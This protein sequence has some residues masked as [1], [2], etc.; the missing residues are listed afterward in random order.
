TGELSQIIGAGPMV[1]R[2]LAARVPPGSADKTA[3][4]L[5]L[6]K[7]PVCHAGMEG[8]QHG[9]MAGAD[10]DTCR[11]CEGSWVTHGGLQR[12]AASLEG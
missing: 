7:C 3:R 10:L 2:R 6:P 8:A 12:L 11:F 5:S 4:R 1:V 9:A